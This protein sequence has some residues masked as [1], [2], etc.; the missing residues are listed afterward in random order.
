MTNAQYLDFVRAT[1]HP[2]PP[3]WQEGTIPDG[4]DRHPV[5]YVDW[6]DA[7]AYCRFTGTR[8]PTE[9]EWEKGARGPDSRLYP[10]GESEPDGSRANLAGGSKLG[11]TTV[12]TEHP[13]GA[14]PYGALDMAGNVWEWV[15]T[16][17][18]PYPYRASDGREDPA[19]GAPRVLRGGS[20]ASMRSSFVRC[21]SRSRSSPGRRSAHIGFRV[22]RD[23]SG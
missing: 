13:R 16:A 23:P 21:A 4:L 19:A 22:A 11:S 9:A 2:A 18:A 20:F 8:L 7:S 6:F 3:H 14:S 12:V 17:Y 15:S 10:W 1:G 5:T